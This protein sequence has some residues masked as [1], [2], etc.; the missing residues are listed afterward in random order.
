MPKQ[1]SPTGKAAARSSVSAKSLS[2]PQP[3]KPSASVLKRPVPAASI[4]KAK[5]AFKTFSLSKFAGNGTASNYVAAGQSVAQAQ[6]HTISRHLETQNVSA[7]AMHGITMAFPEA[8]LKKLLPSFD[9]KARTIDLG[10]VINL[11]EQNMRGTE[12]HCNGNPTLNRLAIQSQVQ[13]I[14]DN[15][16]KGGRK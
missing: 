11:I 3:K 2:A 9:P 8:M 15:V 13:Q 7:S 12:F 1:T 16:K 14:I 5:K 4:A 6:R 10:E